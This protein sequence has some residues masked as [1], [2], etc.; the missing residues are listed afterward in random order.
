MTATEQQA[1][2]MHERSASEVQHG[3]C[4]IER[5]SD[6][7]HRYIN[8][9]CYWCLVL[10][11]R[12]LCKEP[13]CIKATWMSARALARLAV[14]LKLTNTVLVFH[15]SNT[16]IANLLSKRTHQAASMNKHSEQPCCDSKSSKSRCRFH[17]G[18]NVG[19]L[20]QLVHQ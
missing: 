18:S 14:P 11:L 1:L 12:R 15:A 10:M 19:L 5:D 13:L 7:N 3:K 8:G 4:S 17:D 16:C 2:Q 6:T 20:L 9:V